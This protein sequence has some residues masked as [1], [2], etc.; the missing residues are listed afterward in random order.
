MEKIKLFTD[1]EGVKIEKDE[2][3]QAIDVVKKVKS[4]LRD[5]GITPTSEKIIDFIMND[6]KNMIDEINIDL[7]NDL[8]AI[9][10]E[11]TRKRI[12]QEAGNSIDMITE[13][14]NTNSSRF[15]MYK[16]NKHLM[17]IKPDTL[18]VYT[19]AG[20]DNELQERHTHY[21]AD[22]DKYSEFESVCSQINQLV[23]KYQ[24]KPDLYQIF[25]IKD[26]R[27]IP[28]PSFNKF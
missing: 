11:I 14:V 13:F 21:V 19:V 6:A 26:G 8:K 4:F 5:L 18:D 12:E 9:R 2:F 25:V 28:N 7:E 23:K 22:F 10:S 16:K 17:K 15:K 20:Y 24:L 1:Y 3:F 27:C